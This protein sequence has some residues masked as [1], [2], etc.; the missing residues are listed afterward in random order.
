[1]V[2]R[3]G[4]WGLL[5]SLW[6]AAAPPVFAAPLPDAPR[7]DAPEA[8]GEMRG[9]VTGADDGLGLRKVRVLLRRD[10]TREVVEAQRTSRSG[11]FTFDEIPSGIYSIEA[12]AV[13]YI[14]TILAPI[15]IRRG[16]VRIENITLTPDSD[17]QPDT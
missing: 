4:I 7:V 8:C 13:G 3:L 10:G 5:A 16:K 15:V 12:Q 11:H 1:M 17:G 9:V 6:I 14:P 2:R